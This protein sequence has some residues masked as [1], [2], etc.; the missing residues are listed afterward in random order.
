MTCQ[1]LHWGMGERRWDKQA[2]VPWELHLP[3]IFLPTLTNTESPIWL[4]QSTDPLPP[5]K[6]R[7]WVRRTGSHKT[8]MQNA[9]GDNSHRVSI[10]QSKGLLV[11]NHS[12]RQ[13]GCITS[14]QVGC[15]AMAAAKTTCGVLHWPKRSDHTKIKRKS[16][17]WAI[18]M[19]H[20]VQIR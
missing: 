19:F 16:L 2:P 3:H 17:E 12:Q 15:L 13:H 14:R 8:H 10:H 4:L 20:V 5:G 18:F 1:I 7:N 6:A 11:S 9:A